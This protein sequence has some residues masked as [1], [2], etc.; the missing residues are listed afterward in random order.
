MKT[1]FLKALGL[2]EEQIADIMK[3]NGKD[4]EASKAKFSDYDDL[5]TQ[6]A[7]AGTTIDG[8]KAMDIDG[9]KK[10]AED[11]KAKAEQA[12]KDAADKIAAMEFGTLLDGAITASKGKN[13]KAVRALLDMDT[14]KASKNQ[15]EDIKAALE[16]IKTENGYLFEDATTPPPY[17]G[18][19]GTHQ[20]T[21][22]ADDSMRAVM[23][24]PPTTK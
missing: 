7:D 21:P 13:A 11:Y 23:G 17:A 9:I 1:E 14:L 3:E 18:G 16:A 8:F 4:V 15:S 6:L 20:M 2:T 12:E 22:G 24:L 5:K 10:A 19:T